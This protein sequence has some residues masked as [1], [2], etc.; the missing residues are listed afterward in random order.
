MIGDSPCT[1]AAWCSSAG[2]WARAP[3]F[4]SGTTSTQATGAGGP[5]RSK[6]DN[7]QTLPPIAVIGAGVVGAAIA[8]RLA[9]RNAPVL[10]LD[11][12]APGQGAT[13]ASF[14]WVNANQK[15]PR[16]Y[17]DLNVAGMQ[18]YLNAWRGS[19]PRPPGTTAMAT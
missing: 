6:H 1:K 19:T 14:A 7:A 9:E 10:L 12:G 15:L 18:E 13:R 2:G 11:A 4:A 3:S 16:A 17:Y 8:A 5:C